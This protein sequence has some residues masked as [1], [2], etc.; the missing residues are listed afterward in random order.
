MVGRPVSEFIHPDDREAQR[1]AFSSRLA[2]GSLKPLELRALKANG[3]HLLVESLGVLIRDS[4]GELEAVLVCGRDISERKLLEE[5]LRTRE[6]RLRMLLEQA[7][8][9]LW[10]TDS[11]LRFTS[12][13]G[14]ALAGMNLRP[15]SLTGITLQ[16][17]FQTTDPE[18][19]VLM[20]HQRALAGQKVTYPVEWG[21]LIYH[22]H[23]EP[24]FDERGTIVGVTGVAIDVTEQR[25]AE[26]RLLRSEQRYRLLFERNLAGVYRSTLD[27]RLLECNPSFARMLGYDSIE[28]LLA[29]PTW[30][31]Y[32]ARSEREELI[33]S[34]PDDEVR[35]HVE[36]R[37]RRKDGTPVWLLQ[38]D[39]MVHDVELGVDCTEGT[40]IDITERK[41]A[42]ERI[43]H[44]AYHDHLTDLPN[45]LLFHD[46]LSLA[47][48]RAS[49]QGERLAVLF[50]DL[51]HFKLI[52]DTMAHSA[53]DDLLKNVA[54][55]LQASLR[56]EDTVAR[57][58][59][60][61]FTI[62]LPFVETENDATRVAQ[63]ILSNLAAPFMIQG[64]EVYITASIGISIYPTDGEEPDTLIKNADG[65][66]YR[67][68]E[69]GRNSFHFHTAL[70]QHHA[71]VRLD[72]ETSLRHALERNELRLEYQPL[73]SLGTGKVVGV[74]ALIRWHH[75]DRGVV[76][77]K[78]FIRVAEEIGLILPIGDWVLSTACQ[79]LASWMK[80][81]APRLRMSVNISARQFH[82]PSLIRYV[83]R[84]LSMN[85]LDPS[86][87]ELEI[88]ESVAIRD[89]ELTVS[90]L[91]EMRELGITSAIDDFG[92]GYS[93]LSH[94]RTLPIDRLKIDQ[95]FVRD[96]ATNA[97]DEAIATAIVRMA[98]SMGLVVIAEGVETSEQRQILE[99]LDC[100][101]IQGFLFSAPLP[102]EKLL[103]M[104][105]A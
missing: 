29:I 55:R 33:A 75:P 105:L 37:L 73:V 87:L 9:L 3:S 81:G 95:L 98:H 17:F 43:E 19:P 94:L 30:E 68:K 52:N 86:L 26:R 34:L 82:N 50:L 53:G 85:D 61:E 48:A 38:N 57:M 45:R 5:Q 7:P 40:V 69:S 41:L 6:E 104:L 103:A 70:A 58:G 25:E 12:G 49:R 11:E 63:S 62:L 78:E 44:Q 15:H 54:T 97:V 24:L 92:T 4:A 20:A 13:V 39:V 90:I 47:L 76:P 32:Y 93:S 77:P 8:A 14:A 72:L 1:E 91:R 65:A 101:E 89:I 27:G 84:L 35:Q 96:L 67:V 71:E 16:E 2:S 59:G 56:S 74:E 100:D 51:D 79:Q 22:S 36:V 31:L 83:R 60:D 21:G 88:T 99:R 64:R 23:V 18:F 42:E 10:T 28:E 80:S 66:M 102:P 46:R